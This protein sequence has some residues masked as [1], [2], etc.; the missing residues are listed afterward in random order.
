MRGRFEI[1]TYESITGFLFVVEVVFLFC[2]CWGLVGV[3][4]C[5]FVLG[6]FLSFFFG[7]NCLFFWSFFNSFFFADADIREK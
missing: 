7:V 1:N 4:G 3:F 5:Y 6:F 2:F